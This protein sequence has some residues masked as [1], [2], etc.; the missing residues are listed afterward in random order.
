MG[1]TA[2]EQLDRILEKTD[3]V[4]DVSWDELTILEWFARAY[5]DLLA[6]GKMIQSFDVLT[7]DG[8]VPVVEVPKAGFYVVVPIEKVEEVEDGE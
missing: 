4:I 2:L 1:L 6:D 7:L 5:R 8:S 3:E